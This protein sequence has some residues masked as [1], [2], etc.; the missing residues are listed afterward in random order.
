MDFLTIGEEMLMTAWELLNSGGWRLENRLENGDRVD[1]KS[2][3]GKRVFKLS[4][5]NK[6]A[7]T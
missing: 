4:V 3:N 5:S 1:V 6:Q 2:V 7:H